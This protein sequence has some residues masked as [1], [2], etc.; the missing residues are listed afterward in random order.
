[1]T[2]PPELKS[3]EWNRYVRSGYRVFLGGG[4]ATPQA[5]MRRFLAETAEKLHGVE[6]LHFLTPGPMPWLERRYGEHLNDNSFFLSQGSRDTA[7]AGLSDYTPCFVSEIPRLFDEGVLP[8]DTALISVSPPD[9]QGYCS[10]GP[11]VDIVAAAVRNARFVIAQINPRLPRT[12]GDSF[13][14]VSRISAAFSEAEELPVLLPPPGDDTTLRIARNVALLVDDGA[15]LQLGVGRIPDAVLGG[16]GHRNDLGIHSEMFSDGMM[17]LLKSGNINN[18]R[19]SQD[20]GLS[21]ASFALGSRELYDYIADN[22]HIHFRPS[23]AV[24]LPSQIAAQPRM[25]SINGALSVD[26]S[27]QVCADTIGG[28]FYSGIGGQ[29]DFIR[30]ASMSP[31]GRPIIALPSTAKDGSVSRIVTCLAAHDGVVTSRGDVHYVVTEYGIATLRGRSIRERALELIQVAHPKFREALLEEVRRLGWVP[32]YQEHRPVMVPELADAARRLTLKGHEFY[33]REVHPSDQRRLQEFFYSHSDKTLL[34]R[35]RSLPSQMST[36]RAY[37]MVN[38]DQSRDLALAA[39]QRQ[40]PRE[41]IHGVARFYR[42]G[43]DAEVAFVVRESLQGIGLGSTLLGQLIEIARRRQ[44]RSLI[45]Y[46]RKDN[47]S[48]RRLLE[49]FAFAGRIEAEDPQEMIYTL[50]LKE[51]S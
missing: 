37:K 19:K 23:E 8:L 9:A 4:A 42:Q 1:M 3:Y 2:L 26:L 29:V 41:L 25:T 28:R 7:N 10:L 31:G 15:C 35:Y 34:Q 47:Q 36:E 46:V 12:L 21:V 49:K 20:R 27:G 39:T 16:L 33:L 50:Q 14:H 32:R 5:L 38:V 18:S 13:V 44:V 22:P 11:S 24:N 30:G 43:E 45:A 6:I 48:M 17:K 51:E 40:G